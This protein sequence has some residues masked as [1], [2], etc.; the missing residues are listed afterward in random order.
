MLM[1]VLDQGGLN[2]FHGQHALRERARKLDQGILII[3]MHMV[4]KWRI[5][6]CS[7]KWRHAPKS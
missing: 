1:F 7:M 3:R 6:Y 2:K 5:C 4:C